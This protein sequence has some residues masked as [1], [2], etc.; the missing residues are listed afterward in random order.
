MRRWPH[1]AATAQAC[2]AGPPKA[3][4][5][6][7]ERRRRAAQRPALTR[8]SRARSARTATV[9]MALPGPWSPLAHRPANG[10]STGNASRHSRPQCSGS[11][12]RPRAFSVGAGDGNRTRTVSLGICVVWAVRWP[13]LRGALPVSDRERP[14]FTGVNGTLMARRPCLRRKWMSSSTPMDA[15]SPL[16]NVP[17]R[18]VASCS[19]S[20]DDGSAR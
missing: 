16:S 14:F 9:R 19:P 5:R 7:G 10:T 20:R 11:R 13:D 6:H 18:P 15:V 8:T 2:R 3:R 4:A 12:F 1:P 17:A